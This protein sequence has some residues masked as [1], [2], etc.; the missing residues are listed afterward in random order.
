MRYDD[1]CATKMLIYSLHMHDKCF[2]FQGN[3]WFIFVYC[4]MNYDE[5]RCFN[6]NGY[7][8]SEESEFIVFFCFDFNVAAIKN[9]F[10]NTVDCLVEGLSTDIDVVKIVLLS[11]KKKK[12]GN[13]KKKSCSV[14]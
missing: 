6:V 13:S 11:L 3:I 9:V 7:K 12:R 14:T 5:L 8:M 1:V 4:R 2:A 10:V